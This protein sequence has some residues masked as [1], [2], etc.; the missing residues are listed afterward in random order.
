MHLHLVKARLLV[1]VDILQCT[2]TSEL[3][4]VSNAPVVQV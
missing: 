4:N 2:L 1:I 3:C